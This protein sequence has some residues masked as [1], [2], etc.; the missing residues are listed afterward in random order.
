MK[1]KYYV[2]FDTNVL[3]SSLFSKDI[4]SYPIQLLNYVYDGTIVPVFSDLILSEYKEVLSRDIFPFNKK[5]VGDLINEFKSLGISIEPNKL[6]IELIDNDDLIFYEVLMNKDNYDKSLV[7]G[8]IKHFP[9]QKKI[10]TPKEMV[11]IIKKGMY[12][13]FK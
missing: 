2:I 11:D 4:N 8:N 13:N 1:H 7:T 12:P 5:M 3:V 9:I 6:D 10:K